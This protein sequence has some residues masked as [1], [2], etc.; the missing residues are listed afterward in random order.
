MP[1]ATRIS[2]RAYEKGV[3]IRSRPL[4][5]N[6]GRLTNL[7]LLIKPHGYPVAAASSALSDFFIF[8]YLKGTSYMQRTTNTPP[9]RLIKGGTTQPNRPSR[10]SAPASTPP[11]PGGTPSRK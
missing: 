4:R 2:K 10:P 11:T 3:T 9:I 6:Q 1:I 5:R 8:S 7:H